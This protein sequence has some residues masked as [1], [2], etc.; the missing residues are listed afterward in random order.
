MTNNNLLKLDEDTKNVILEVS[1]LSGIPQNIVKEVLEYLLCSWAI[2][3]ADHSESYAALT[4]PYLG[5][6]NVKYKKDNVLPNGDVSPEI[7]TFAEL[8]SNFK[9][10]VGDIYYEKDICLI[11]ML[12]RKIEQAIMV[13][14]SSM[15]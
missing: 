11:P 5:Q 7:D 8:S 2:K 12:Q 6:V 1:A 15:D 4:V 3:I 10:L 9:K 13:A 14:S